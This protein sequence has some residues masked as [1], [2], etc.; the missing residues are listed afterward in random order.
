LGAVM[1]AS[2]IQG[3]KGVFTMQDMLKL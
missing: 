1:A 2:W 3:R